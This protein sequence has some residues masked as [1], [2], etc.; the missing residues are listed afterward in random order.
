MKIEFGVSMEILGEHTH[1]R[2]NLQNV[3]GGAC[4]A[5]GYL[6]GYVLVL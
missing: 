2:T 1:A 6:A 3:L 4:E 5:L